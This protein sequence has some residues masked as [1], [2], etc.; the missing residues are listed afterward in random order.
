MQ[1]PLIERN[2]PVVLRIAYAFVFYFVFCFAELVVAAI[3]LI[4]LAVVLLSGAP[5]ADLKGFARQLAVYL[6]QVVAYVTWGS[7]Q[8]PYPF[9]EWPNAPK[10]EESAN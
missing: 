3:A 6:Q 7:D 8:K 4:Q 5:Q 2:D 9:M 10:D 1:Q